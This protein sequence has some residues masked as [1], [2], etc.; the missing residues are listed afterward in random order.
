MSH[1]DSSHPFEGPPSQMACPQT[2]MRLFG[3]CGCDMVDGELGIE[4]EVNGRAS[5]D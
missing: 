3:G 1:S 2:M 5:E 4:E